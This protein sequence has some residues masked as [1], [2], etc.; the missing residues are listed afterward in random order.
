MSHILKMLIEN[1][2]KFALAGTVIGAN[3]GVYDAL[4][5]TNKATVVVE[6]GALGGLAGLAAGFAFPALAPIVVMTLPG[7]VFSKYKHSTTELR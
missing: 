1:Q 7:Y 2:H 6:Y 4:K 3:Y 5:T